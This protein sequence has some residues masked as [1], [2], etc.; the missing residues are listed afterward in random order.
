MKM[1]TYQLPKE[2]KFVIWDNDGTIKNT[3]S[4]DDKR[5]TAQETLPNVKT[6]MENIQLAGGMNIVCSGC[7]RPVNERKNFDPRMIIPK[8]EALME[9]LPI[10]MA[11]F[12]PIIGGT[13]CWG[14]IKKGSRFE[15]RPFHQKSEYKKWVGRFK[16]P[17]EGMLV[18]INDILKKEFGAEPTG[19]IIMIGDMDADRLAAKAVN[20]PFVHADVIHGRS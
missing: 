15:A 16:K 1:K 5:A 9:E 14:V 12:S 17:D 10:T 18:V 13:E 3:T 6:T 19:Q 2:V 4:P 11:F 20:I 7:K 8:M